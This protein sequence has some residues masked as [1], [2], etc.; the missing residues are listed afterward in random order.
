VVSSRT[1]RRNTLLL[2]A[3]MAC[4]SAM[5]QLVAA[6]SSLTFVKVT[7]VQGLLGLGPAIFLFTGAIAAYQA[8]RAM[9]RVGRVPV[10]AVGFAVAIV[11]LTVTGLSTRSLFAPGV[12]AGFVMLGAALGTITLV[13]TAGGDM[14]P[15]AQ[16]GRGIA[17]VLSG[18]VL[19]ALLGPL[20]FGPLF[21]G[22]TF[23]AD[24]LAVGWFAAI[25]FP[26]AGLA[27]VVCVR[28]DPRRIAE[29]LAG[30]APPQAPAPATPSIRE[31][32]RRPGV[33]PA[34]LGAFASFGVMASV[35]N[36][37][38]YVVVEHFH[39]G[40]SSVFSI[41]G[42]HVLGMYAFVVMVGPFVDR[43]GRRRPLVGG[44]FL[45][46][47]CCAG[48]A[49]VHSVVATAVLL[50]GLGLG[51]SFSFLAASSELADRT[52]PHERGRLLGFSDQLSGA[53]AATLAIGFGLLLDRI[54]VAALAAGSSLLVLLPAV[55]LALHRP[56]G[57][58]RG[59]SLEIDSVPAGAE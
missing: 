46:G 57:P 11:G 23:S 3:S 58:V 41:I 31:L 24:A 49:L 50:F 15:P 35:M 34:L 14:Y 55:Y 18:A 38:G 7:G 44:L 54:G 48:L 1:I 12:L 30:P 53:L 29:L 17:L 20:V 6:I 8:G 56:V 51:W 25:A 28:P 39:H 33:A 10:L 22:R 16:R 21:S 4:L 2:A 47:A 37:T 27:L 19:G 43:V 42:A 5:F 45:M 13:R 52:L 32:V 9:D 40:Q 59:L 36:L 26:L